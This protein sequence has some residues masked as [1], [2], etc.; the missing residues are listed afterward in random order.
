MTLLLTLAEHW[1]ATPF[2]RTKR[3]C[4]QFIS[5]TEYHGTWGRAD[6]TSFVTGSTTFEYG[7]GAHSASGSFTCSYSSLPCYRAESRSIRSACGRY[8]SYTWPVYANDYAPVC[9]L[10]GTYCVQT[11]PS[12][13]FEYY[14]GAQ[15]NFAYRYLVLGTDFLIWSS[16]A[17][18]FSEV[19]LSQ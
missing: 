15:G 2:T 19:Y 18:A 10:L 14:L 13:S 6:N 8:L 4:E 7:F 12:D 9:K 17:A 1:Y 3:F 5:S 16:T 11:G